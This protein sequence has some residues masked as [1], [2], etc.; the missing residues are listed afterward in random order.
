[1]KDEIQRFCIVSSGQRRRVRLLLSKPP[2]SLMDKLCG[3][4]TPL[5]F[6]VKRAIRTREVA[7][8]Q[9]DSPAII[10]PGCSPAIRG[11]GAKGKL[12][13]V[14]GRIQ[15]AWNPRIP[16]RIEFRASDCNNSLSLSL[17]FCNPSPPFVWTF[18]RTQFISVEFLD[19]NL[20]LLSRSSSH[21]SN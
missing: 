5:D 6:H 8:G 3:S 10:R 16:D 14:A 11:E 18:I 21:A 19:R 17:D 15:K 9:F 4:F 2:R 20:S 12:S 1:M 13:G 7:G